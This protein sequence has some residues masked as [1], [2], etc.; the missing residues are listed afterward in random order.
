MSVRTARQVHLSWGQMYVPKEEC[1]NRA[2][3]SAQQ[4]TSQG[5]P[6]LE[7][8]SLTALSRFFFHYLF[9]H[10]LSLK[11]VS[12]SEKKMNAFIRTSI[13]NAFYQSY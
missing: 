9:I 5:I 6:E 8:M 1:Q 7:E 11:P 10:I 2:N 3:I 4:F 13:Y 12:I